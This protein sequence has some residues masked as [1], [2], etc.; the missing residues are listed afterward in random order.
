MEDPLVAELAYRETLA[1]RAQTR[2]IRR[3]IALPLRL[4]AL[5]YLVGAWWC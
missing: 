2:S 3:A 1:A 5:A 4:L